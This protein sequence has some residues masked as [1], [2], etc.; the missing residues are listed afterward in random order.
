[1]LL[2]DGR[3]E[4]KGQSRRAQ[5]AVATAARAGLGEKSH[6]P[7]ACTMKERVKEKELE[8]LVG[9]V[10]TLTFVIHTVGAVVD[11]LKRFSR[12]HKG[13]CN[14]GKGNINSNS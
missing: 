6:S 13:A 14:S 2:G 11:R 8:V 4:K 9:T 1:M 3:E 7:A 12:A 5:G 10:Y